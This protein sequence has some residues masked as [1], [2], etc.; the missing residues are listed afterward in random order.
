[1]QS[2]WSQNYIV[3]LTDVVAFSAKW[4]IESVYEESKLSAT[5]RGIR[6][7]FANVQVV[8]HAFGQQFPGFTMKDMFQ[9][10]YLLQSVM[11]ARVFGD[12]IYEDL[13]PSVYPA[14][15]RS[16]L[17]NERAEYSYHDWKKYF[18]KITFALDGLVHFV[19]KWREQWGSVSPQDRTRTIK[20][21]NQNL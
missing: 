10:Q 18:D 12:T 15:L 8:Q 19:E 3:E 9:R 1:M 2:P 16:E 14:R 11:R 7:A 13:D 4:L 6:Q 5:H 21:L 20:Y 17:V